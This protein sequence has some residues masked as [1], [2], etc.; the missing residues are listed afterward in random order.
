MNGR[1][2]PGA[3]T[4]SVARASSARLGRADPGA[5]CPRRRR[6]A[7]AR[8]SRSTSRR[9]S[10]RSALGQ[11]GDLPGRER[12][13]PRR[14]R[15]RAARPEAS[16]SRRG[17]RSGR[18]RPSPGAAAQCRAER[19]RQRGRK[20]GRGARTHGSVPSRPDSSIARW[21]AGHLGPARPAEKIPA[22]GSSRAHAA[23]EAVE[24]AAETPL[25]VVGVSRFRAGA[26]RPACRARPEPR[27]GPRSARSTRR[28]LQLGRPSLFQSQT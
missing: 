11:R 6:S 16:G 2:W 19:G 23:Q 9:S 25:E 24:H 20:S 4:T 17:R 5:C 27:S 10:G 7:R 18:G 22:V 8:R 3:P 13:T 12:A 21:P 26:Q 28:G 15:R 1:R 14:D